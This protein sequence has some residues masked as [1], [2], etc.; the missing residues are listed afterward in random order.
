MN[1]EAFD[2]L[3][4]IGEGGFGTVLLVRKKDNGKL[5]ALKVLV[6]KSMKIQD[7]ER[8]ICE[9]KAM[10]ELQHPF[11]VELFFAFQDTLH[12]YFVLEFV[13]GG[14]LYDKIHRS[15]LPEAWCKLYV[16]E[17]ALAL[18]HCHKSGYVYRDLKAENV[19]IGSDGHLK[20]AD[21]GLAKKIAQGERLNS[22]VGSYHS[23]APEV[24]L[25]RDYGFSVDYWALGILF[26]EM[27]MK[28]SPMVECGE[29]HFRDLLQHYFTQTHLNEELLNEN[30][31]AVA[32]SLTKALLTVPTAK[33][34]GCDKHGMAGLKAHPFFIGLDWDAVLRKDVAA[35]LAQER[36][37]KLVELMGHRKYRNQ[38]ANAVEPDTKG[39]DANS[40]SG[41]QDATG[42]QDEPSG[43]SSGQKSK[44]SRANS[45]E[46]QRNSEL[47][48]V[49]DSGFK[50][51]ANRDQEAELGRAWSSMLCD[52]A[53]RSDLA[54]LTTL[55][56][57]GA[58]IDQGDY[59]KRTALHLAASE[60]L[61]EVVTFLI[62]ECG[63]DPNPVDR[64]NGT[65]IDDA[66]RHGQHDVAKY[67][68]TKGGRRIAATAHE[69]ATK[70]CDAAA[71]SDIERLKE[72]MAKG[73]RVDMGDYDKRTALHLSASEGLL[74]V[75]KFLI[76]ECGAD[77]NPVD[78][79][80]GTPTDD[81]V[82]HER[83]EVVDYLKSKGGKMREGKEI[84]VHEWATKLC[85]AAASSDIERLKDLVAKGAAVD[86][87][88]YD[89]RTALHLGASEGLLDVVKHLV[90][91]AKAD[92]NPV[93]RWGFS[94]IDDAVRHRHLEVTEFLRAHGG[95]SMLANH[96]RSVDLCAA[97]HQGN[98]IGLR[99]LL[100]RGTDVNSTDYD[101]RS[102]MH[103]AASEGRLE[104]LQFLVGEAKA[105]VGPVDRWGNTPL[106]DARRQGHTECVEYLSRL[107]NAADGANHTSGDLASGGN[108]GN[109]IDG[110]SGSSGSGSIGA[111]SVASSTFERH[112][113]AQGSMDDSARSVDTWRTSRLSVSKLDVQEFRRPSITTM[114]RKLQMADFEGAMDVSEH[115]MDLSHGKVTVPA[116]PFV[117]PLTGKP[118]TDPVIA[119]DGYTYERADIILWWI[120]QGS[121]VSPMTGHEL[122]DKLLVPNRTLFLMMSKSQ[123]AS[124]AVAAPQDV[125][126]ATF[127]AT[128][129]T[130]P[131]LE[132][133]LHTRHSLPR[134]YSGSGV[135]SPIPSSP[136]NRVGAATDST[137]TAAR[138][139]PKPS[140][141][142]SPSNFLRDFGHDFIF[143]RVPSSSGDE[144][145]DR[146]SNSV[147]KAG[148]DGTE[149]S[150]MRGVSRRAYASMPH[151]P[152]AAYS[153][154]STGSR[155]SVR[156]MSPSS[157]PTM[158]KLRSSPQVPSSRK[159]PIIH[160]KS[161]WGVIPGGGE[162]RADEPPW[163]LA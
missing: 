159:V 61:L 52:A 138:A 129:S 124:A 104:V 11:V 12:L 76:E 16:A 123:T 136:A 59:D 139:H 153:S 98:I 42:A 3:N 28:R 30:M 74:P 23:I 13:A 5:Y 78:R 35:P 143:K 117:C 20:L 94:P 82:R 80:H 140:R 135:M 72:L 92:P 154:S 40:T 62:E 163:A 4:K 110:S 144:E 90:L 77:P 133:L 57:N 134:S 7:A 112:N 34:I 156:S 126:S 120:N 103:L 2:V 113:S 96:D 81:A 36:D 102:A 141:T 158:P 84:T 67:L 46:E 17:V 127:N 101:A 27:L 75:V 121:P 9:S 114:K 131:A 155:S 108:D 10:Q 128:D 119:M 85:D 25:E 71:S 151:L 100:A 47:H 29:E 125:K 26:C 1:V 14:D 88:D 149:S 51:W 132:D 107:Q 89:K 21:F 162:G 65:P 106:D 142:P 73:A 115:D 18:N 31:S 60:G 58:P 8:A 69:W 68:E 87:A 111:A 79:W 152:S 37:T 63:A 48:S 24:F 118:F 6:K 55:V 33:R 97:A 32:V 150:G 91:D 145:M 53:S 160:Q 43:E 50:E 157:L 122:P 109:F 93:D 130:P 44:D 45:V 116:D 137:H 83:M 95:V 49:L 38:A 66:V 99:V 39:T 148:N 146:S 54:L 86:M 15:T 105:A 64:W 70:L 19:L 147:A 22:M 56:E 161:S 41:N